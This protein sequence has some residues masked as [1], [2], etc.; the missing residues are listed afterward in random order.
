MKRINYSETGQFTDAQC[1]LCQE[2]AV[3]MTRSFSLMRLLNLRMIDI[4][5]YGE[6]HLQGVLG[7]V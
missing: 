2:I 7:E 3:R 5:V 1:K 4:V 6:G